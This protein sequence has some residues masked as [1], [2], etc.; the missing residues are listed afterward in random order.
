MEGLMIW[1]GMGIIFGLTALG[2][3]LRLFVVVS[4]EGAPTQI[5]VLLLFVLGVIIQ[6]WMFWM[7]AL[8]GMGGL[9]ILLVGYV[10]LTE[11]KLPPAKE[12]DG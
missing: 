8:F 12:G 6:D 1:W 5:M 3:L 10:V 2:V 11:K 4:R 7:W 9:Y